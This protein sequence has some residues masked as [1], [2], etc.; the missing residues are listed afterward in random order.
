MVRRFISSL[1]SFKSTEKIAVSVC[2]GLAIGMLPFY[3]FRGILMALAVL[4]MRLNIISVVLGFG[5]SLV[6][7][8]VFTVFSKVWE[9]IASS[10]KVY[11]LV[12]ALFTDGF[13][14][15]EQYSKN[16]TALFLILNFIIAIV[17]I[18]LFYF[19]MDFFIKRVIKKEKS[20]LKLSVAASAGLFVGAFPVSKYALVLLG[21]VLLVF[22]FN[23]LS[24]L[25]GY[26]SG[27]I[28]SGSVIKYAMLMI[29][30]CDN[31]YGVSKVL[32]GSLSVNDI[33]SMDYA[34]QNLI[35]MLIILFVLVI[36]S[37]YS[38]VRFLFGFASNNMFEEGNYI[39]H[40][41]SGTRWIMVKRIS[42]AFFILIMTV[43][44][45]FGL[46]L[47]AYADA[48]NK[49][50]NYAI[51]LAA[52]QAEETQQLKI[53]NPAFGYKTEVYAFYVTWD[54]KSRVSFEKNV[55]KINV[56]ITD[57]LSISKK[58]VLEYKP[59][60]EID[61]IARRHNISVIPSLSNYIGDKWDEAYVNSLLKDKKQQDQLIKK[62]TEVLAKNR[63][64]GLNLD[65][66]SIDPK[67]K[68]N[69]TE[70]VVKLKKAL[71]K[72]GLKLIVDVQINNKSF[73]YAGL[74]KAADKIVMMLYDEHT[75]STR[76]GPVSSIEWFK[77]NLSKY[78]LEK[79]KLIAGIGMYGYDWRKD[80][81]EHGVSL[82]FNQIMQIATDS[83]ASFSWDGRSK[84]PVLEYKAKD[85]KH[86]IY[87]NDASVFYNQFR[88]A[89]ENGI[90]SIGLWRL[91]SED[92][93]IW[94]LLYAA[95]DKII[96][97]DRFVR[98]Q[99]VEE[100][101]FEGDGEIV[102]GYVPKTNGI[103][104]FKFDKKGYIEK[105]NYISYPMPSRLK[106]TSTKDKK[107]IA[108]TFD[109]GPDPRYT[110][111]ILDILK[112]Y[113]VKATFFIVGSNGE[114]YPELISRIYREGHEIGNHT[115][116]HIDTM[117]ETTLNIEKELKM[118]NSI[119]E[120]AT[121]HGTILFRPPYDS[122][123]DVSEEKAINTFVSINNL[124][125]RMIGNYIDSL[126]WE[127]RDSDGIIQ[128]IEDGLGSGNIILMHD[129]GGDRTAT[130]KALPLLIE[131]LRDKGMKFVSV[132]Q[133]MGMDE[134]EIMPA[135]DAFNLSLGKVYSFVNMVLKLLPEV[136]TKF[137]YLATAIGLIRFV[138]LIFFATMQRRNY[139]RKK[140][141][142]VRNF[143]PMVS[144]V[145]AAYNE[146]KVICKTVDSLLQSDYKNLEVLVVNDGSK[147][148]TA[149]VVDKAYKDVEKVRLI[150]KANGGK[151]S[152]VN[153][154]F[155]EADGEIVVVLDAD[156]VIS[157][158]A[159]SL[160]VRHFIDKNVAAVSGNVKVGNVGNIWTT[161]QHVEYVTGLN[162]ER[163]AFDAL[164][165]ITVVPGAIG[166]WRKEL[167]ASA[168][169]YKEDTLAEDADITLTFLRQ[170]YKIVYE[171]GAKAFT[172]APEDLK[173]LLKQRV[174]W[175]YGTLQCLW[176]H[177]DALF[178][179]KQKTLGFIALPN[180]WL[181]QVVFQSLSPLTDIL[182]FLGIIGGHR[183][184]TVITYI[185][186]FLIDLLITCYAFHLEGEKKRPLISLFIQRIV[187]RQL[188]TYVV[189]KSILSALMG[190]K[191]GWNKLKR[192]GNVAQ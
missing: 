82:T 26:I 173:S 94:D 44:V 97:T 105:E 1:F 27:I 61:N 108:L 34:Q 115:Y 121:G 96:D 62:L 138:F 89:A 57:W 79:D 55:D 43:V 172:E 189:Y 139:L 25:F 177:R 164:N 6:V 71:K 136:L 90:H 74:S 72:E 118:T 10:D 64:E 160:L 85:K 42:A 88:I 86:I 188:M 98:P 170:G 21:V 36:I 46:S 129:S 100:F 126:D 124:G 153:R 135:A 103:R 123:V 152:A 134:K 112:K 92:M 171:E 111:Q 146:E 9:N 41:V 179:K 120:N 150:N 35:Y 191:V 114:K 40:D 184:E 24:Y 7:P 37:S 8:F 12:S 95:R 70:F 110:P 83:K 145:V 60:K 140:F 49:S 158:D 47:R 80:S 54:E 31:A 128:N 29:G 159:I 3:G 53:S 91:G 106:S 148:D 99:L 113:N 20:I 154:G 165:C 186:F 183:I 17:S 2:I 119:I 30:S 185:V 157:K 102:E 144:I 142:N 87:F 178:S 48:D 163:R 116:N 68:K 18:G 66:E 93:S 58:Y 125:Y 176:K 77:S 131:M 161:W 174:R 155:M 130:V 168:G 56:L 143:S 169:Y 122:G 78:K 76:P 16:E 4:L 69:Y 156:T 32:T 38:W 133:L 51:D 33:L 162:L 109:D 50:D 23:I 84:A 81:S 19:V 65:F 127:E 149:D 11:G 187:Y 101:V 28:T 75:N 52:L 13:F 182:F 22:R 181:Y 15:I 175:S 67:F 132:G 107:A 45:L 14:T 137:F 104:V 63:Y 166:A 167:V 192:L 180:T 147:D 5:V 190:V 39:F 141:D 73:D 151:S 117:M 59:Q